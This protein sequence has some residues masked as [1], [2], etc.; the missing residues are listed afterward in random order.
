MARKIAIA[1]VAASIWI[2]APHAWQGQTPSSAAIPK[3]MATTPAACS[4]EVRDYVTKRTQEIMATLPPLTPTT[5]P[6]QMMAQ[7]RARAAATQPVTL[8]RTAMLKE[9]AAKFDP[10]T[11]SQADLPA[12]VQLYSD[13]GML[14]Q[15]KITIERALAIK[16]MT[17]EEFQK[18]LLVKNTKRF[19]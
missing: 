19:F 6:E 7:Q 13:A 2:V 16:D 3:T 12:L 8:A 9:C 5:D 17:P 4:Q 14:D 15:A 1:F 18:N 10:N 11:A